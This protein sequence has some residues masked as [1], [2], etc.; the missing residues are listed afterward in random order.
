MIR[1]ATEEDIPTI[2]DLGRQMHDESPSYRDISYDPER[3]ARAM[4]Q[5]INGTGVVFLYE[6]GGEIRGGLAGVIGEF[7]FSSERMASDLA[8]FLHPDH[9]HG[10]IAVKLTLAFQ[11][12]AKQLGARR[13]QMGITTGVHTEDT[14]KLYRSL[15]MSDCG[16][17][18]KKDFS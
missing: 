3:V 7:W 1:P 16:N 12:W 15:G 6:S 11:S 18:F 9:R 17:L 14:G 8:L 10:L 13:V 2:V 5:L 4:R